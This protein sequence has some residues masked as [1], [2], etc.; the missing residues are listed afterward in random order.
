MRSAIRGRP[1]GL[2]HAGARSR[3]R[4]QSRFRL[5]PPLAPKQNVV[6]AAV[7]A[8]VVQLLH[9]A[10]RTRQQC[11]GRRHD[12]GALLLAGVRQRRRANHPH[13]AGLGGGR[14]ASAADGGADVGHPRAGAGVVLARS[15]GRAR[16]LCRSRR[17]R[18]WVRAHT[19]ARVAWT[20]RSRPPREDAGVGEGEGE[21]A[22][23]RLTDSPSPT[24][25]PP[26]PP[27]RQL[28]GLGDRRR[29]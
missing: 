16:G 23:E 11:R 2:A 28:P 26:R 21:A 1:A 18:H 4:M 8:I 22:V 14:N 3:G 27:R 6:D 19:L 7:G 25:V 13:R 17:R 29:D 20:C 12:R 24:A 15:A 5:W 10:S 9:G